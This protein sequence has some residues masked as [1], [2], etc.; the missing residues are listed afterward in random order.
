[1]LEGQSVLPR[2][3]GKALSSRAACKSKRLA[4]KGSLGVSNKSFH[5]E[6]CEIHVNSETQLNQVTHTSLKGSETLYNWHFTRRHARNMYKNNITFACPEEERLKSDE[7]LIIHLQAV[8]FIASPGR[9][10]VR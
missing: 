10:T 4:N 3:R 5:C 7:R 1:M 6:V 8:A 9:F 2:R